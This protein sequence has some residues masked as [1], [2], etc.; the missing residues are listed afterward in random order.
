M[1]ARPDFPAQEKEQDDYIRLLKVS[2]SYQS[3]A[4]DDTLVIG[5]FHFFP[6]HRFRPP[7]ADL[8][9]SAL[10]GSA[11]AIPIGTL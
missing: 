11:K 9:R 2:A 6:Q 5:L 1:D 7:R 10:E 4:R 8:I 3:K